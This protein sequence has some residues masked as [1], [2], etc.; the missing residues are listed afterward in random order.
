VY[1][2]LQGSSLI[3]YLLFRMRYFLASDCWFFQ[4]MR[5]WMELFLVVLFSHL[6]NSCLIWFNG[7]FWVS[8]CSSKVSCFIDVK[9][10]IY[11]GYFFCVVVR[12]RLF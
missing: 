8:A 6:V 12:S 2:M 5:V 7:F 3:F 10:G 9:M 1:E 11:F 4:G